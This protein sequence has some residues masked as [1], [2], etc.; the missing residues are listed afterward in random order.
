MICCASVRTEDFFDHEEEFE[1]FEREG[2]D[3]G[4]GELL[5]SYA[6]GEDEPLVCAV[7][8]EETLET[9]WVG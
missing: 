5:G 1:V 8:E 9:G 3:F 2:R 4:V 7:T 6:G